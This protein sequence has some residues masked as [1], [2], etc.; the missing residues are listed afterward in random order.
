V[1]VRASPMW[2]MARVIKSMGIKWC[3]QEKEQM[4]YLRVFV[5]SQSA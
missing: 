4:S 3:F 2:L 1:T 5:F